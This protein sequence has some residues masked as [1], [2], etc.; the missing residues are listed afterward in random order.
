M[1]LL[2]KL[3]IFLLLTDGSILEL[4]N[5]VGSVITTGKT[6]SNGQALFKTKQNAFI[7]T[8]RLGNQTSYL[9]ISEGTNL[10]TSHFEIGGE[11]VTGGLKGFIYGERGVWRPGDNLYLTFV[12]QDSDKSLPKDIPVKFELVDPL[13]HTTDTQV[14]T[15]SENN[16]YPITTKTAADA[17]T[18][19][20]K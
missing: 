10:S 11:K 12:L 2:K 4:I 15:K 20:W 5:Y 9:K 3:L 19:L 18:G 6:D 7:I 13:G 8:A 16:F 1:L 17:P 14:L